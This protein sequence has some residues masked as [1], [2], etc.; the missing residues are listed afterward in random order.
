MA[1]LRL[2][3]ASLRGAARSVGS[4]SVSSRPRRSALYL[5]G[6]NARHLDKASS[7]PADVLLLDCEDA[8]APSMKPL[9]RSQI[10]EALGSGVYT[11]ECVVRVNSLSSRWG[12]D[13]VLSLAPLA[14]AVL[15]PKAES[16]EQISRLS[17]LL[18]IACERHGR[19]TPPPIWCT[20]ETPLGVVRAELLASMPQVTCLVAGTSDL[21]A[22][23]RCDGEWEERT[24]LLPSLSLIVLAAR[25]HGKA[26]LDGVHL[27]VRDIHGFLAACKQA[28]ALGFDGKTL[29]HPATIA[30]ANAVFSPTDSQ[31]AHAERVVDA[32]SKSSEALVVLDGRLVEELHVREA[33]RLLEMANAIRHHS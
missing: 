28:R 12:E 11:Q 22:D 23:L 3:A 9:A 25:A 30:E 33:Q 29:I 27:N 4:L 15:L 20:I 1:A 2:A 19:S 31:L 21:A 24:A 6:S 14:D 10:A 18:L 13:D 17:E 16:A 32:F 8:V 7:L 5:P 26:V